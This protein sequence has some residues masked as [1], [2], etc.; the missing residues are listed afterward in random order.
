LESLEAL[1]KEIA[2]LNRRAL[3]RLRLGAPARELEGLFAAK[4]RLS[5]GL[6][7]ALDALGKERDGLSGQGM[8]EL[9]AGVGAA[10]RIALE[11]EA[12]LSE[13]LGN[14]VSRSGK[15]VAY[16]VQGRQGGQNRLDQSV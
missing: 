13:A 12:Q 11:L 10:Q 16:R 5:A 15:A 6:G 4:Q 2:D 3:E 1:Y 9:S 8:E 14:A 7:T